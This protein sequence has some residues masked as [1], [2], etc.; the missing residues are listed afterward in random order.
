MKFAHQYQIVLEREA[1]PTEWINSAIS[2]RQLKKCI[3]E[4]QRELASIGLD[5]STLSQ[6]SEAA[7]TGRSPASNGGNIG[8]SPASFQYLFQGALP[9]SVN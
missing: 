4:V 2:Y 1:F 8:N 3:N 6:L 5:P 9:V 7:E